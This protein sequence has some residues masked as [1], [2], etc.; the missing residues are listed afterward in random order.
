M[1][2]L[3]RLPIPAFHLTQRRKGAKMKCW[4]SEHFVLTLR[5]CV[6]PTVLATTRHGRDVKWLAERKHPDFPILT[7]FHHPS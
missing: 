3:N 4:E 2:A 7:P 1:P 5:L 6:R